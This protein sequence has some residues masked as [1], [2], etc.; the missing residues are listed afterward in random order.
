M[1]R[2]GRVQTRDVL[3]DDVWGVESAL[4]TRTVDTHIK[5]LR[6]KLGKY[7]KLI[8]TVRGIG[9]KFREV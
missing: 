6:S 2:K 9:Y 8:E 4:I 5:S 3:L 7:G 1:T